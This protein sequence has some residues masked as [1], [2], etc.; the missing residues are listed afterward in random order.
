MI[1]NET[2][3]IFKEV[4]H[5]PSNGEPYIG[6]R[7]IARLAGVSIATVSRVINHP[8]F[9]SPE[10]RARVQ[11]VIDEQHYVPNQTAKSLFTRASNSVALFVYDMSN[12]FFI[13]L[14]QELNQVAFRYKHTLLICDTSNDAKKE[15]EYL[16]YCTAI[17]VKGIILTEGFDVV[18]TSEGLRVPLVM[19]DRSGLKTWS[20]VQSDNVQA[21]FRAVNY[22]YNLNHRRIGCIAPDEGLLSISNRLEGFRQAAEHLKIYHPEYVF[23]RALPLNVET[24]TQALNYFL[25]LPEPPTAIVCANDMIAHGVLIRARE[26]NMSLPRDLSVIGFDG[27]SSP[28]FLYSL[29]TLRQNIPAIAETLFKL[30]IHPPDKP[31]HITIPTEFIPGSTCSFCQHKSNA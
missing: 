5:M 1:L 18:A 22:L 25:S 7:D 10:T 27:V 11:A 29:T 12:P 15:Q 23:S 16:D 13:S 19:F 9:T 2:A 26:L 14:I 20:S 6:I 31:Q 8:E 24:G 30:C 4:L 28:L 3:F 17:R 21:V